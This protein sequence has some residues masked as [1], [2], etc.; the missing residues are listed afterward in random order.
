MITKVKVIVFI[1]LVTVLSYSFTNIAYA[2]LGVI[3]I[4]PQGG[5]IQTNSSLTNVSMDYE[6]V[7]LTYSKP[8][9]YELKSESGEF[10]DTNTIM[11]VHVSAIFK[12]MNNGDKIENID[13][14]FPADTGEF[15]SN[16]TDESITNFKVNGKTITKKNSDNVSMSLYG[17]EQ[18]ISAYQWTET[19]YPQKEN[20]VVI[21]Y[22]SV[23]FKEGG[24]NVYYLAY[25]LG[26]GRGWQGAIKKGDIFF[27]LPEPLTSYA[28]SSR[29][30]QMQENKLPFEVD[31]NSIKLSFSNYE[32]D[33]DEVILL[34]VYDFEKVN[35]I[36]Q[37]KKEQPTFS[38]TLKIAGLFRELSY[39]GHCVFCTDKTTIEA[40]KYYS[41]ALDKAT[42]KDEVNLVL[43]SFAY[44]FK[45]SKEE[46]YKTQ[47]ADLQ[48][49]FSFRDCEKDDFKC[50]ENIYAS[51][52]DLGDIPFGGFFGNYGD[53]SGNQN[54]KIPH[55][56]F[57][58]KYASKMQAYDPA[59]STII[60]NFLKEIP[61]IMKAS[62]ESINTPES[63]ITPES[64]EFPALPQEENITSGST[65]QEQEPTR[66]K[67]IPLITGVGILF[68]A[69]I[70]F[71]VFRLFKK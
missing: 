21:E 66:E 1:L 26:T 23:V 69:L 43:G 24:Y 47:M 58:N 4:D 6:K 62:F 53:S 40:K 2:D 70:G 28:V 33:S 13:V 57:L 31:S 25:I 45:D 56:D 11:K 30:P 65:V 71:V 63:T 61:V 44:G 41:L 10:T 35:A 68:A 20:Q 19:F 7:V 34:S 15:A 37:L 38:N 52:G 14:F 18:K 32:P 16:I 64:T 3:P 48:A 17:T 12:M 60:N 54:I 5:A 42:S 9:N 46:N 49:M 39:G 8:E 22:D 29:P 27:V 55:E 67:N 50:K 59:I 51:R 36:E